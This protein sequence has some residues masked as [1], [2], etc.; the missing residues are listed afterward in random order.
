MSVITSAA[1]V[2]FEPIEAIAF[3][4]ARPFNATVFDDILHGLLKVSIAPKFVVID[5]C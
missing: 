2:T 4:I 5:S 3:D 1:D